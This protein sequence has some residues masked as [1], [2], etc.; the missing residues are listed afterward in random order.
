MNPQ[1]YA[2]K[3]AMRVMG[4]SGHETLTW[5]KPDSPEAREAARVFIE[6]LTNGGAAAVET[7]TGRDIIRRFDPEAENILL[8]SP[9]AGG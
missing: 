5:D 7:P 4:H 3:H 8:I 2:P 1:T 6:H 9:Y